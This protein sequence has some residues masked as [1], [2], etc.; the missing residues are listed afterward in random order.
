MKKSKRTRGAVSVFL[1]IILVPCILVSSIFVD[2]SRVFLS[3]NVAVSSADLALNSL[4]TNY[5]YDLSDWYGMAASCQDIEEFY[6]GSAEYFLRMLSSQG[7]SDE[8]IVLISDYYKNATNDDT[9]YDLLEMEGLT[10][11][12]D[13]IQAVSGAD[14]TNATIIKNQ[15]VEFMKY[16]APIELTTEIIK[17][18]QDDKSTGEAVEAEENKPLVDDKTEYYEAEGE[19]LTAAFNSYLAIFDYFSAAR[20]NQSQPTN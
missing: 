3:K 2:I 13:I 15:V 19:L 12:G 10:E 5:D 11:E 9:I 7:I 4:M 1:V 6:K 17:R 8:E 18:L 16:R 14:M 20:E